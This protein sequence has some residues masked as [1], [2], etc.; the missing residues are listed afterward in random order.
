MKNLLTIRSRGS[1]LLILATAF[2][3][4]ALAVALTQAQAAT[5][6][7][8][9]AK[10]LK[11]PVTSTAA[12]I[13]QGQM[14]YDKYCAFCHGDDA[15]GDGPLA[16]KDSHPPNII[17]A[18]S[19]HGTTDGELYTVIREGP[20]GTKPVMKPFQGKIADQD[21]WSVVNYLKSLRGAGQH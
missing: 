15:K 1:A 19:A 12:S 10:K 2:F 11:N 18:E 4:V 16:P 7:N 8:P 20:G 13:A 5:G 14:I 6:G 3:M 17:D 21:I 9:E